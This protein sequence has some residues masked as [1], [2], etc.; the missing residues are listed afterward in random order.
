ML[1][2]LHVVN[3]INTWFDVYYSI[4]ANLSDVVQDQEQVS[5][6][7]KLGAYAK[8]RSVSTQLVLAN[9]TRQDSLQLSN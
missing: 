6:S 9:E 7:G 2:R 3:Y 1:N 5:A 4:A 8:A